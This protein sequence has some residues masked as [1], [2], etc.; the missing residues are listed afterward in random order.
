M[1]RPTSL[2]LLLLISLA[3][4][5]PRVWAQGGNDSAEVVKI[6][7]KAEKPDADGKQAVT[8]TINIDKPWHIYA[9]PVELDT[10]ASVQT[11]VKVLS[12]VEDAKFTYPAG[13]LVKDDTV[14]NYRK[15]EGTITIKGTVRR[16]RGDTSPLEMSMKIQAC[17]DAKC[18]LPSTVKFTA[19]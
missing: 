4:A 6:T 15:Y 8:I 13:I 16:A 3:L 12:K 17:D 19:R 2:V 10:L 5:T 18:R 7:A 14:G 1:L 11:N 9:N